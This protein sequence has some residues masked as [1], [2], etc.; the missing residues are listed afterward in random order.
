MNQVEDCKILI[1]DDNE[2]LQLMLT[3]ILTQDGYVRLRSAR[4][5][6]EA[7]FAFETWNPDFIILDIMLPDGDGFSFMEQIRRQSDVPVLF[8]SAKDE[9]Q[10]RLRGL[11]LGADDYLTKPFL[12]KELLLRMTSILK[13]TYFLS[14]KDT[15][16]VESLTIGNRSV[17]FANATV[18]IDSSSNHT[19]SRP[20]DTLSV[21][22]TAKE[23]TLLKKLADNRG[24]IVTFDQ[25]SQAL[26]GD[27]YYGYE[28]S[29][30]VHIRRL[31]EKIE[32]DPSSPRWLLTARGLGYKLRKESQKGTCL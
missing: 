11:G 24:N 13:R 9:D 10:D 20:D 5:V 19:S 17:N 28:N 16:T 25:L 2:D 31:R 7:L 22:L 30:M 29:L 3:H 27:S 26:W 14:H 8:L 12:P 4:N 32:D 23:L 21:T 6:K 1:V 15:S 18:T